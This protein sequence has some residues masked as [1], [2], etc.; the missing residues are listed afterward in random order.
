M[1]FGA[2]RQTF[3]QGTVVRWPRTPSG[4]AIMSR[5]NLISI[6]LSREETRGNRRCSGVKPARLGKAMWA[7]RAEAAATAAAWAAADADGAAK[8]AGTA[9]D[10]R[11]AGAVV[12][13]AAI[14][15]QGQQGQ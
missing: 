5:E 8:A 7:I 10:A 4:N 11:A 3:D 14:T 13:A 12:A 15:Q 1:S 6:S 9:A 2:D